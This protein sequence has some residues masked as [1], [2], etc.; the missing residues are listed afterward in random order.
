RNTTKIKGTPKPPVKRTEKFCKELSPVCENKTG[1]RPEKWS[2]PGKLMR[3]AE[4]PMRTCVEK[5][6]TIDKCIGPVKYN[7][8]QDSATPVV[9]TP[10][11]KAD[12][13]AKKADRRICGQ[14][15]GDKNNGSPSNNLSNGVFSCV[16]TLR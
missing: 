8:S 2:G 3:K 13:A 12:A 16:K 1:M 10:A 5:E 4:V 7:P 6:P 15:G 11:T 9:I 14:I